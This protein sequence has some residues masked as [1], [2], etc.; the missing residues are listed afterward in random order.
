MA[1][2]VGADPSLTWGGTSKDSEPSHNR[3]L[4]GVLGVLSVAQW[5]GASQILCGEGH[6]GHSYSG[7]CGPQHWGICELFLVLSE[8]LQ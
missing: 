3:E 1:D 8:H 6:P 4:S 7:V 2:F 5:Q